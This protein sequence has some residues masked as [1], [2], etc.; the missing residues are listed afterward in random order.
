MNCTLLSKQVTISENPIFLSLPVVVIHPRAKLKPGESSADSQP[1]FW[2][3]GTL[4]A[5]TSLLLLESPQR[6]VWCPWFAI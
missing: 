4:S 5:L 2:E 1:S 3:S 6:S